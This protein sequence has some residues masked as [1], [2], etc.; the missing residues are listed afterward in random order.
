M[1]APPAAPAVSPSADTPPLVPRGT[2]RCGAVSR[3]GKPALR[4]P[5]PTP[6]QVPALPPDNLCM[7]RARLPNWPPRMRA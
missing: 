3:R 7:L 2:R 6:Q 1:S 5:Y 4:A